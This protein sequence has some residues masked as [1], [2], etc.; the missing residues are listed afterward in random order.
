[1]IEIPLSKTSKTI[2]G[3]Y[4]TL[5]SDEDRDLTALNWSFRNP[6]TGN[7]AYR[8][9][10]R[11]QRHCIHLHRVIMERVL[12]RSLEKKE[13]VDHINGD[14]LDNRRENLRIATSSQNKANTPKYKN[15]T[16]GYKG[17]TFNKPLGKWT[18][19]I[20]FKKVYYHLGVFD[21]PEEGHQAYCAA[22]ERLHGE[23]ANTD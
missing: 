8:R 23:F 22:A 11:P 17:V 7:Y 19:R 12:G 13:E 9:A 14:G 21:T 16:S 4:V 18:A 3:K 5:V 10:S 15:N 2:A 1:M 6:S 20:Q